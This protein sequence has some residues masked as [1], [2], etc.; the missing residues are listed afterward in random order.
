M[1]N[2]SWDQ[3]TESEDYLQENGRVAQV[4]D[5]AGITNTAGAP[6]FAHFAKGGSRRCLRRGS[7]TLR[8]RECSVGRTTGN[9]VQTASPPTL[10]K[11]ARMGR[12]FIMRAP[13]LPIW[14]S[15]K[16]IRANAGEKV[17]FTC[18]IYLAR[19]FSGK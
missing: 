16:R 8:C 15:S 17:C 12:P 13:S 10:A 3:Y 7:I 9:N 6:S 19:Q 11:N 18:L 14:A 2:P 5:L 4:F 1:I